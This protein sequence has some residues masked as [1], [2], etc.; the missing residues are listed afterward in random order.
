LHS[1]KDDNTAPTPVSFQDARKIIADGQKMLQ[2]WNK[3]WGTTISEFSF[4]TVNAS[5]EFGGLVK[6]TPVDHAR[7]EIMTMIRNGREV[8]L[9]LKSIAHLD[10]QSVP[11]GDF[12]NFWMETVRVIEGLHEQIA[13]ADVAVQMMCFSD[14]Q[15]R[16]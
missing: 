6:M 12:P 7:G 13:H 8:L 2:E 15:T 14:T 10:F 1:N 5:L 4:R 11:A 16:T 9:Q 3:R